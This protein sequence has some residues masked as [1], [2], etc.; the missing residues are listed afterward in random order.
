P[1]QSAPIPFHAWL[2]GPRR[3]CRTADR[4]TSLRLPESGGDC[5]LEQRGTQ[6]ALTV[7]RSAAPATVLV[8]ALP[9][10]PPCLLPPSSAQTVAPGE[11]SIRLIPNET[12]A[13]A[14]NG[15][16]GAPPEGARHI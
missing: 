14:G 3:P 13:A 9:V 4:S 11:V 10:P 7:L 1:V 16:P 6:T 2:T 15:T 12:D 8:P 5:E